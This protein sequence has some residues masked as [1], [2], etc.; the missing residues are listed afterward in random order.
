MIQ[1]D[2]HDWSLALHEAARRLT[3]YASARRTLLKRKRKR[4]H[5][6]QMRHSVTDTMNRSANLLIVIRTVIYLS[7]STASRAL[8][9]SRVLLASPGGAPAHDNT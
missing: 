4:N 9:A 6:I 2:W 1:D 5:Q 3:R 8:E 7:W